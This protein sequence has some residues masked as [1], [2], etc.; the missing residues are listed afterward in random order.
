MVV[1]MAAL[2]IAASGTAVAATSLVKGDKLIKKHSLSGNRLR[3][4]TIT[5]TQVN[6]GKLGKVPSARNADHAT[7]ANSAGSATNALNAASATN[8]GN[9]S[10][11]GGQPATAFEHASDFVRAGLVKASGGQTVPFASFG[12]FTL[13]LKCTD[14]GGGNFTSEIDATSTEANSDMGDFLVATP[15]TGQ[16]VASNGPGPGEDVLTSPVEFIAPSG[17][18]YESTL[19]I[20]LNAFGVPCFATGLIGAS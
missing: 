9:A 2:V 19:S 6:L 18:T 5:G 8:A 20:G 11:L 13:T 17:K 16:N 4:H 7:S 3:N 1:S 12:P 10:T 14:N 15:G